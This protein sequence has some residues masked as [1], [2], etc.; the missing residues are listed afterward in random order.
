MK[1]ILVGTLVGVALIGGAVLYFL[2]ST[3]EVINDRV[4]QEKVI[5]VDTL[6]LRIKTAQEAKMGEI[7]AS[8]QKAYDEYIA[9]QLRLIEEQV[10]IEYI[11]ELEET[12]SSEDYWRAEGRIKRLIRETFPEQ[13]AIAIAVAHCESGFRMVQSN[14]IQPYGREESFGIFQIHARAWDG[15]AREL[16]L[17]YKNSV[18]ENIKMARYVYEQ[19]GWG[20]WTCFNHL[21]MR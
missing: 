2:P 18:P 16:E 8:A 11:K 6:D 15:V 7:E 9:E 21:A 5:E 19:S 3:H 12:I 20:A 14:H 4:V 1:R 10:K 13:P 17:D